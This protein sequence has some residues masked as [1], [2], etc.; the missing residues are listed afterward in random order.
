MY[1][2]KLGMAVHVA[3]VALAMTLPLF[4]ET[5][6]QWGEGHAVVTVLPA[7]NNNASIDILK[8]D[9]QIKVNGKQASITDWKPL[10]GPNSNLEMV[11]LIDGSA[12]ASLGG[13]LDDIS[14]FIRSLPANE[15]VTV[16]Y[17][18][19]GRAVLTGPL[20]TSTGLIM[21]SIFILV[22]I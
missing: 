2:R 1:L 19:A 13:Q 15:K 21:S 17:M 4:P 11:I 9:L 7:D 20:S 14:G 10:R 16:G 22:L 5:T 8:R 3:V 18:N 12:R 6:N